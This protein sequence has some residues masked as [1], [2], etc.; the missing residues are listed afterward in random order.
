VAER[1]SLL[2]QRLLEALADHAGADLRDAVGQVDVQRPRQA[3]RVED[4]SAAHGDGAARGAGAAAGRHHRNLPLRREAHDGCDLLDILRPCDDVRRVRNGARLRPEQRGSGAVARG[5]PEIGCI[6][7]RRD[8]QRG[9]LA[10]QRLASSGRARQRA[11]H[12]SYRRS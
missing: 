1:R 5:G 4:D 3:L 12:P 8:P 10:P 11:G 7:R 9:D 6:A 2:R